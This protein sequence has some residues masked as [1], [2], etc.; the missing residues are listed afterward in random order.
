[1]C[2]EI[3]VELDVE[4]RHEYEMSRYCGVQ[5]CDD[6]GDHRG[7]ERCYCGWSRTDPGHGREELVEM[8]E[9]IEEDY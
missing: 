4:H 1:M 9:T 3:R 8:G 7:L 6:C 5:V 2:R